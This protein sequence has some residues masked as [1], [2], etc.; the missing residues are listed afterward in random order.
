M[1]N[2][3]DASKTDD[4]LGPTAFGKDTI[5]ARLGSGGM[6]DA[7]L[8]ML[9]GDLG[10][11]R[12]VVLKRMHSSLGRDSTYQ[13]IVTMQV[14]SVPEYRPEAPPE[15]DQVIHYALPRDRG[16]RYQDAG[17][18]RRDIERILNDA[19]GAFSRADVASLMRVTFGEALE[20]NRETVRAFASPSPARSNA[21][22]GVSTFGELRAG[23]GLTVPPTSSQVDPRAPQD[24]SDGSIDAVTQRAPVGSRAVSES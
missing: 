4:L 20:E 6:A 2:P 19:L 22:Y 13:N 18:M 16:Q 1:V 17:S 7:L 12:L 8:A 21:V 5:L 11:Q 23:A 10:F 9:H 3:N 15:I 14:P 24:A